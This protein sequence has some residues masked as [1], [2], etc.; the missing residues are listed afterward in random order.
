MS[1][2]NGVTII[3]DPL[4]KYFL[5]DTHTHTNTLVTLVLIMDID[6]N[7]DYWFSVCLLISSIYNYRR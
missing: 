6:K 5:T 3:F 4:Y 7:L 2:P 1:C